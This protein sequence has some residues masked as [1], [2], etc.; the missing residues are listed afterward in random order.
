MHRCPC[1]LEQHARSID[2][3]QIDM[4]VQ[5]VGPDLLERE[6]ST[7]LEY[8]TIMF[9][10]HLVPSWGIDNESEDQRR[11][12]EKRCC[13]QCRK[14]SKFGRDGDQEYCQWSGS[15]GNDG[16]LVIAPEDT[17]FAADFPGPGGEAGVGGGQLH[18]LCSITAFRQESVASRCNEVH[19][20]IPNPPSLDLYVRLRAPS[21]MH[22][23]SRTRP[24]PIPAAAGR[25]PDAGTTAGILRICGCGWPVRWPPSRTSARCGCWPPAR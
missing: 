19:T 12:R 15:S 17:Y 14:R 8:Q 13:A 18:G 9:Q 16:V 1:A 21:P 24:R 2:Q 22:L 6:R 23:L 25:P 3:G 10:C 7:V 11:Q 5:V 4:I 20:T